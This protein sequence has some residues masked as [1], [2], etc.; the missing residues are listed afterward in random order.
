MDEAKRIFSEVENTREENENDLQ[1]AAMV[2]SLCRMGR[3][4]ESYLFISGMERVPLEVWRVFWGHCEMSKEHKTH[5]H[6]AQQNYQ[7]II[8]QT[9]NHN[10]NAKTFARNDTH[11]SRAFRS[12]R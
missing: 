1:V 3:V 11:G 2:D 5:A 12:K 8:F 10:K 7:L 9:K 6:F 4:G